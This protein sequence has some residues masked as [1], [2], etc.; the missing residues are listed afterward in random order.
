MQR[1]KTR[2]LAVA[3]AIA[4]LALTGCGPS[5]GQVKEDAISEVESLP[6]LSEST[7]SGAAW[8]IADLSDKEMIDRF[9]AEMHAE[10]D[11]QLAA[12]ER[13]AEAAKAA[14]AARI[15]QERADEE[16][17]IEAERFAQEERD[18]AWARKA[19]SLAGATFKVKFGTSGTKVVTGGTVSLEPDGTVAVSSPLAEAWPVTTWVIEPDDGGDTVNA[20]LCTTDGRCTTL[21]VSLTDTLGGADASIS[22][23]GEL[24]NDTT[25][26]LSRDSS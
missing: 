17:R 5:I 22:Q 18:T 23:P 12:E 15:E 10:S 3:A 2:T 13:R 4:A 26:R 24:I 6:G 21:R 1:T 19:E 25:L 16:A 8:R 11:A 14:E 20:S 9:V 7:K